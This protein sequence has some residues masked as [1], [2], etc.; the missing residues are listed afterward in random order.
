MRALTSASISTNTGRDPSSPA[1][2]AAP[3]TLSRLSASKQRLMDLRLQIA[4]ALS[5]QIHQ[6]HQ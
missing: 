6:F 5:S 3:A 2:T 4:Q 1:K